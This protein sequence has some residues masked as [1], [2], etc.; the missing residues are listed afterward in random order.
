MTPATNYDQ[1]PTPELVEKLRDFRKI[2]LDAIRNRRQY[3]DP[4]RIRTSAIAEVN[5]IRA[6]L[7]GRG[8]DPM[9]VPS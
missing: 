6:V 5:E 4:D 1:I 9:P 8:I 7:D 2:A 3:D